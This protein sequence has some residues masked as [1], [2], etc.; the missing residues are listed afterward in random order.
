M[1]N[2]LMLYKGQKLLF[3]VWTIRNI[4]TLRSKYRILTKLKQVVHIVITGFKGLNSIVH[5]NK[6]LRIHVM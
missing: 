3:I 6:Y 2:W 1:M 5:F 4:R